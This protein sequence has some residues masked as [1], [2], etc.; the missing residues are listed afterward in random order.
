MPKIEK[1]L[2]YYLNLP[3]QFEFTKH[4]GSKLDV[5]GRRHLKRRI[6]TCFE[7]SAI[8]SAVSS[9]LQFNSAAI[10]YIF[11]AFMYFYNFILYCINRISKFFL[12][13]FFF[14]PALY[15]KVYS[16]SIFAQAEF[17]RY[18]SVFFPC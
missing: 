14:L 4:T 16:L 5:L 6:H 8:T 10:S 13:F 1:D 3:W 11:D 15:C 18:I 2:D 7:C 12:S 9:R 17:A